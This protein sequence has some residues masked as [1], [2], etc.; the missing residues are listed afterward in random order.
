MV[1]GKSISKKSLRQNDFYDFLCDY[2]EIKQQTDPV[3]DLAA[4]AKHDR[5]FPRGKD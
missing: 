5:I 3:G 4:D 1:K 2:L